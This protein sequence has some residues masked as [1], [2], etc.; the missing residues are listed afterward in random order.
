MSPSVSLLVILSC[1]FR[2]MRATI[3]ST[4]SNATGSFWITSDYY[5]SG[6]YFKNDLITCSASYCHIVCD[7][8][9]GCIELNVRATSSLTTLVIQCQ[10]YLSC[11][12][13]VIYANTTNA[14]KVS[15]GRYS[16]QNLKLYAE[17]VQNGVNIACAGQSA[18]WAAYVDASN[19]GNSLIV[20]CSGA[21]SCRK[22]N[23]Y[24]PSDSPCDIHCT[25][26]ASCMVTNIDCVNPT[27]CTSHTSGACYSASF[28]IDGGNNETSNI[29]F[30][31]GAYDC[32]EA[33]L[34]ATDIVSVD[35]RCS[36]PYACFE[37]E[38]Y[39]SKV[40]QLSVE[41]SGE[42][43]CQFASI[44]CPNDG[45]CNIDC[46]D[47]DA[48]TGMEMAI[49]GEAYDKLNLNC[50]GPLYG[51]GYVSKLPRI[52]CIDSGDM[53]KLIWSNYDQSAVCYGDCCPL[54]MTPTTDAPSANPSMYPTVDDTSL[55]R[56]TDVT[57]LPS[58]KA[59]VSGKSMGTGS[60]SAVLIVS[61]LLLIILIA[62][63]ILLIYYCQYFRKEIELLKQSKE[64]IEMKLLNVRSSGDVVKV[65]P[66]N[67]NDERRLLL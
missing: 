9:L 40:G 46:L 5:N 28:H 10:Q 61:A 14:V 66:E 1:I 29:S 49:V 45:L 16:C 3:N 34:N 30:L 44:V 7:V 31:C 43:G 51:C 11:A 62:A 8:D 41:C 50:N 42:N 25:G 19:I 38:I 39:A 64:D 26:D 24:C 6:E 32:Y 23:I 47:F 52:Y 37:S 53:S 4:T 57:L 56:L 13:A 21:S 59:T 22:A 67:N 58:T 20:A 65:N 48:C 12:R 55:L 60:W 33:K 18:C 2:T 63:V 15:C 54:H 35:I 17:N 36:N 27:V